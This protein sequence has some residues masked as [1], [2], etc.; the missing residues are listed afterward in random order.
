MRMPTVGLSG[1][2]GHLVRAHRYGY[3]M[4]FSGWW[5]SLVGYLTS[6]GG[7]WTSSDGQAVLPGLALS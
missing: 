4:N 1:S 3:V 6:V 5:D 7:Y 2:S